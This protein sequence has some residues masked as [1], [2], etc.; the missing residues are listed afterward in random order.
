MFSYIYPSFALK[1]L[2]FSGP[3]PRRFRGVEIDQDVGHESQDFLLLL[4]F[5]A[6]T[7]ANGPKPSDG[8]PLRLRKY[9]FH[10]RIF[11]VA[12]G[13]VLKSCFEA[14]VGCIL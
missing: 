1:G 4:E 8:C 14:G 9:V 7:A 11:M 10:R 13:N 6:E 5:V 3:Q 2:E 12:I